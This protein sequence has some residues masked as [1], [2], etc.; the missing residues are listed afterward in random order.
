MKG[1]VGTERT[2]FAETI[3]PENKIEEEI[4]EREK[5]KNN[6]FAQDIGFK[7]V[8]CI[9]LFTFLAFEIALTF[10]FTY[11]QAIHLQGFR[12]DEWSFRILL[13]ATITQITF[14]I[15]RAV[16]YLFPD[17]SEINVTFVQTRKKDAY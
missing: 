17:K 10:L 2:P 4:K 7:K 1:F 12:L 5:L 14:M 15:Q 8:T 6:A 13:G 11:F 3:R 9:I 16:Q